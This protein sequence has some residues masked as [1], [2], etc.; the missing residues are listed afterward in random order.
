MKEIVVVV[1][2]GVLVEAYSGRRDLRL[3]LFDW[4]DCD[5][6]NGR[7]ESGQIPCEPLNKMPRQIAR[8]VRRSRQ[9]RK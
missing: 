7:Y 2:G 5:A 6:E 3:V 9:A 8:T 4:D 1:R